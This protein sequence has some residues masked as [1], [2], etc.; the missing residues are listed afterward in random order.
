MTSEPA[1]GKYFGVPFSEYLEW[2]YVNGSLLLTLRDKTPC[3]AEYE[4]LHPADPTPALEFGTKF[5][6]ALLEPEIFQRHYRVLP[7]D[8]PGR[9]TEAMRSAKNPSESSQYRIAWW[10]TWE[11]DGREEIKPQDAEAIAAMCAA[12]RGTQARQFITGGRSEV[13][14]VWDDPTTGLRCKG[15]LDFVQ[16]QPW[17]DVIT[18][19]KTT[20]DAGEEKFRK[21]VFFYGYFVKAAL[22]A[23]A[24]KILTGENPLFVW[25]AVEK[26]APYCS[27]A[28]EADDKCLQAGRNV[29]RILL[30]RWAECVKSNEYPG[31]GESVELL[32]LAPWMLDASGVGRF[33]LEPTEQPNEPL[34]GADAFAQK[35]GLED[36][37]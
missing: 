20:E 2:P 32:G 30:D 5:H 4:R 11:A 13:S 7:D 8:A 9:P 15:R 29:Y 36:E 22:Y 24:W 27:K 16:E 35:Y 17:Q 34:G 6:M 26:K 31:Y 12:V 28:W 3:H 14:L 18:D 33:N 23:D 25:L 19:V 1:P 37:D 10:D 21:S